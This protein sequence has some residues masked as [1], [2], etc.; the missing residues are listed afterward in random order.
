MYKECK[1]SQS[2]SRQQK[3]ERTLLALMQKYP[4]NEITITELYHELDIPRKSFYRYFDGKNDALVMG[5][6]LP[7]NDVYG[8]EKQMYKEPDALYQNSRKG[9]PAALTT[10]AKGKDLEALFT[11]FDWTYT[12]EGAKPIRLTPSILHHVPNRISPLV[13]PSILYNFHKSKNQIKF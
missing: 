3:I 12:L 10:K 11:F 13:R 1:R 2:I 5:A 7:I 6:A 4:Y 8:G 9:S